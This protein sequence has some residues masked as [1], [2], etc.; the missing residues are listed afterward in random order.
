MGILMAPV[1]GKSVFAIRNEWFTDLQLKM[2][3]ALSA[4]L[5]SCS[6]FVLRI[7]D[8]LRIERL[9]PFSPFPSLYYNSNLNLFWTDSQTHLL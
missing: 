5:R 2:K 1:L 6:N 9:D 3:S 4:L 8:F 7:T